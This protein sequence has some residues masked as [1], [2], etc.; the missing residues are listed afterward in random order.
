[1]TTLS[2]ESF[3]IVPYEFNI[4]VNTI[5]RMCAYCYCAA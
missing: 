5:A 4:I 3:C 1:M 2:F